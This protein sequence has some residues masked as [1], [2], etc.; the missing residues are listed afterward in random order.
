MLRWLKR[1]ILCVLIVCTI[2]LFSGWWLMHGSLPALEGELL[3]EGITQTTRISRDAHGVVTIDASS[4][5]DAF[6]TLGYVH[7]QERFFEM[8]LMRRS[9][10]GELSELF[11][12][13]A[14]EMDK[15][16]RVHQMRSRL[17]QNIDQVIADK[18]QQMSAYT[19]GVNAGL[20]QLNVRPWPYLV[21]RQS[22]RPWKLEDS[23]LTGMAM[24]FD[25]QAG[26]LDRELKLWKLQHA[27]PAAVFTLLAHPGSSWDAPLQGDSIGD[28]VLPTASEFDLRR[29]SR[30]LSA[31]VSF[32]SDPQFI[33]SNQSVCRGRFADR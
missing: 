14:L 33:G 13:A 16:I 21:L 18:G 24:Y 28:A 2:A 1:L 20:K 9:A 32:P 6:Y 7:A 22:P 3:A 25:L 19:N 15:K 29:V 10:A 8:D 30:Q 17:Q 11:G 26:Q 4:E 27:V 5:Q 23:A 31:L 12:T